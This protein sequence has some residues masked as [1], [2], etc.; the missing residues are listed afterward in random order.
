M[1]EVRKDLAVWHSRGIQQMLHAGHHVEDARYRSLKSSRQTSADLQGGNLRSIV[2]SVARF[3]A[4]QCTS[5]RVHRR[6]CLDD[7]RIHRR[8]KLIRPAWGRHLPCVALAACLPRANIVASSCCKRSLGERS[9]IYKNIEN[10]PVSVA[11]TG[12]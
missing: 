7:D 11:L 6:E 1:P 3:P 5:C 4:R 8:W 9:L 10:Q 12:R 2:D